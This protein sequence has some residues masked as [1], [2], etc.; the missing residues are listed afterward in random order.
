MLEKRLQ[1]FRAATDNPLLTMADVV[2]IMIDA[3]T[4]DLRGQEILPL[5]F[6]VLD[7]T[8]DLDVFEQQTIQ[9]L[10]DWVSNGPN[11]LGAM[12]RDRSGPGF[13]TTALQYEDRAAVAFLDAWWN[14]IID[15]LL[16]D[17]VAVENQGVMVGGR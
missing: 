1:A 16:P 14:N 13:D 8:S 3:G 7:D 15:A 4:T 5:V 2:S 17:L 12:R 10:N 9:L 6:D 11:G